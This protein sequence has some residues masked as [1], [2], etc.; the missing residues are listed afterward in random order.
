MLALAAAF[1]G[2][3]LPLDPWRAHARGYATSWRAPKRISSR[4]APLAEHGW[5]RRVLRNLTQS[6]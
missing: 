1:L 4:R 3:G 2:Y 6:D 5:E